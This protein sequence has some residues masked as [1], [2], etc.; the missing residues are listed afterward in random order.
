VKYRTVHEKGGHF[1]AMDATDLLVEDIRKFFG[2]EELSGTKIFRKTA[3]EK[4]GE[5]HGEL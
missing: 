2:D 3:G 5:A 4:E 1:A